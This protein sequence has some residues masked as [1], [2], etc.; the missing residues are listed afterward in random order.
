LSAFHINIKYSGRD[1][2]NVKGRF[3][4]IAA[5]LIALMM[6]VAVAGACEKEEDTQPSATAAKTAAATKTAAKTSAAA[7]TSVT[8]A[9]TGKTTAAVATGEQTEAA[10]TEAPEATETVDEGTETGEGDPVEGAICEAE[11]H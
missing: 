9:A 5:L 4:R 7:K 8:A 2:M 6:V 10:Q 3:P 11:K 1:N